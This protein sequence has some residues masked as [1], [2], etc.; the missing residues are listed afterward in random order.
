MYN[1]E[2]FFVPNEIGRYSVDTRNK[3]LQLNP[4][5]SLTIYVQ[6]EAPTDQKQRANWLLAPKD[7]GFSLYVRAYW[8]KT[9]IIDGSWMP[10]PVEK[11]K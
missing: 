3:D 7:G 2:H 6:A 9:P 11:Q 10:P 5:G 1:A 8:P 4:D